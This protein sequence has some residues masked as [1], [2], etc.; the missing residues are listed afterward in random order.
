MDDLLCFVG[1]K[2]C[3]EKDGKLLIL[4]D[5]YMGL[6]LPGGK[7]LVGETDLIASLKREVLEETG[8]T[9]VVGKPFYTWFYTIPVHSG[10][11][12][13]GKKIFCIGYKCAYKSGRLKL[14]S[15]HD[16][17]KWIKKDESKQFSDWEVVR[18]YF[19]DRQKLNNLPKP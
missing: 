16:W 3:I 2:A 7:V 14:S 9:I 13:A 15:E 10:H 5:P 12:H 8:L 18:E 6:D 17:Y 19:E 4:H 11:P 1:Q